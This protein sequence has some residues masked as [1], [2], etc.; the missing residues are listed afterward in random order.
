[1]PQSHDLQVKVNQLNKFLGKGHKVKVTVK[2]GNQFHLKDS[3]LDQLEAIK[4]A[5]SEDVGTPD[6]ASRLQ[7]GGVY[8]FFAPAK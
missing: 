6:A 5:V 1:M 2:F 8:L 4:E 7:F 3:A